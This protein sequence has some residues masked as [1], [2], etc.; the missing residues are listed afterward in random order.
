MNNVSVRE[1]M[2]LIRVLFVCLGNICRSPMAEGVFRQLVE[3]EGLADRF[4]IES[5][6]TGTWHT[7]EPPHTGT[8]RVLRDHGIDL[9]DKRARQV[10]G[11]D[12]ASANYVVAM[13]GSNVRNLERLIS[14]DALADKTYLLLDFATEAAVR[15]VPDPYYEGGFDRVYELVADGAQG[16][17]DHIREQE[18]F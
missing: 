13:D 4:E 11:N 2:H 5:V 9:S 1:D 8:Q 7:G 6:G 17:L 14:E 18:G 16:L 15:D 10:T 3:K 12:V